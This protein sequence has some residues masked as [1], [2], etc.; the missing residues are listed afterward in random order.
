MARAP[1]PD[2]LRELV[3]PS[4]DL[5]RPLP[6]ARR[7]IPAKLR[8]VPHN[9]PARLEWDM[10]RRGASRWAASSRGIFQ[11]F[12][13]LATAKPEQ[14]QRFASRYGPLYLC[15]HSLPMWHRTEAPD[16]GKDLPGP[17]RHCAPSR[18]EPLERWWYYARLVHAIA[19]IGAEVQL[20]RGGAVEDWQ[21]VFQA[22]GW[23]GGPKVYVRGAS[24][25]FGS[26]TLG[27]R[28]R[29]GYAKP[30][31]ETI[32]QTLV[33]QSGVSLTFGIPDRYPRLALAEQGPIG[34]VV[35]Q[36]VQ[37]LA[38]E[39]GFALCTGCQQFFTPRRQPRADQYCWCPRCGVRAANKAAA[40]RFRSRLST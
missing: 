15:E 1:Q 34:A 23:G 20:A 27:D 13:R 25:P 11:E 18:S 3:L 17:P 12:V 30:M 31:L 19:R 21:V 29:V 24:V 5:E 36:L 6:A 9:E 40:R 33:A 7:V 2:P 14:I 4:G 35:L 37:M 8:L 38:S 22:C 32:V 39:K 16:L 26:L 28:A 10:P